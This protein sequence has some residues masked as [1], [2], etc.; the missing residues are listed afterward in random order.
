MPGRKRSLG[1][2]LK[3]LWKYIVGLSVITGLLVG[4]PQFWSYLFPTAPPQVITATTLMT[5]VESTVSVSTSHIVVTS[6][7]TTSYK[8]TFVTTSY[9]TTQT[10]IRLVLKVLEPEHGW[11]VGPD[12]LAGVVLPKGESTMIKVMVTNTGPSSVE[13]ACMGVLIEFLPKKPEYGKTGFSGGR[14]VTVRP[15]ESTYLS[16]AFGTNIVRP[17]GTYGVEITFTLYTPEPTAQIKV[18]GYFT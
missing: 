16:F 13:I 3:G 12:S 11:M 10:N 1:K 7:V 18:N 15:G 8:E 17:Q 4:L 6:Y 9:V 2:I 5:V 14:E